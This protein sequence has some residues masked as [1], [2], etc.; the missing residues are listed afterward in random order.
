MNTGSDPYDHL[1]ASA[2][3]SPIKRRRVPRLAVAAGLTAFMGM[4]GAGLAFATSG[5]GTTSP[6]LS[7]SSGSTTTTVPGHQG[8]G[9]VKAGG[10]FGGRFG[11]MAGPAFAGGVGGSIVHGQYT[12]KDGS[13][14]RTI[15]IQT[16]QVTS[17]SSS[18][19]SVKSGDGY[20]A[21]YVV[22]STTI[23]D[24]QSGGISTIGSGDNVT[25]TALVDGSTATAANITDTTKIGSSRQGF[26]FGSGK[27]PAG[28]PGPGQPPVPAAGTPA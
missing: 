3:D 25:L 12:T 20:T 5:G 17:V 21:T 10:G 2:P 19:I 8:P 22:K 7:A 1:N 14:Y 4:A 16:G 6:A 15:D 13:G 26:G 9:R 18:S 27:G 28:G 23:V 11:G 24:A